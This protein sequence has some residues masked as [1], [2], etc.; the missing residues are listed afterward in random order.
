METRIVSHQE[1]IFDEEGARLFDEEFNN[2]PSFYD[3]I[4]YNEYL[5]RRDK[6]T[7]YIEFFHIWFYKRKKGL[8]DGKEIHHI[9]T[10]GKDNR[11]RNLIK[12]S[13]EDHKRLHDFQKANLKKIKTKIGI[14]KFLN[15]PKTELEYPITYEEDFNKIVKSKSIEPNGYGDELSLIMKNKSKLNTKRKY[16]FGSIFFIIIAIVVWIIP[17]ITTFIGSSDMPSKFI[18][19]GIIGIGLFFFWLAQ[20]MRD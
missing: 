9:N 5:A 12:L 13:K 3:V 4:T 11:L 7:K 14:N 10:N 8:L 20:G 1:F 18:G 16:N 2:R 19:L 6:N 15:K 17:G